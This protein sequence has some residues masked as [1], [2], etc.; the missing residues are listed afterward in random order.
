M[1]RRFRFAIGRRSFAAV[2]LRGT[3]PSQKTRRTGHPL[4]L[5]RKPGPPALISRSSLQSSASLR[6]YLLGQKFLC[7]RRV[8][9][10]F[11]LVPLRQS[12]DLAVGEMADQVVGDRQQ[13]AFFNG[14]DTR[15]RIVAKTRWRVVMA[16]FS[17][18]CASVPLPAPA[19]LAAEKACW[20]GGCGKRDRHKP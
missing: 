5:M 11:Y 7:G 20:D 2:G 18:R 12:R 9:L 4:L 17:F 19:R 3:R 14:A 13:V 10:R 8:L 15:W 16:S 6:G 1:G